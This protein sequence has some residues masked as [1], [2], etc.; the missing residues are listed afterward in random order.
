L[1]ISEKFTVEH[2]KSNPS[3]VQS[4][5]KVKANN[6]IYREERLAKLDI[7]HGVWVDIFPLDFLEELDFAKIDRKTS[8][9]AVLQTAV[10]YN[11][12]ILGL[13]KLPSK[14]FFKTL[15]LLYGH[16]LLLKKEKLMQSF[17]NKNHNYVVDFSLAAQIYKMSIFEKTVFDETVNVEFEGHTFTA[18]KEYDKVLKQTYGN[19]ME[20]PPE[21][22][23]VTNHEIVEVKV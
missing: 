23:R 17:N 1:N 22:E 20:L 3:Y 13:E 16:K 18:P 12:G 2:S 8:K 6:T 9:M 4:F 21:D 7:H 19:Y 11:A 14:I 15:S 5:C 10:D